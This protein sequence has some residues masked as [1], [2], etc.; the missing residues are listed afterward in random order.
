[1]SLSGRGIEDTVGIDGDPARLAG[2][3]RR[4]KPLTCEVGSWASDVTKGRGLAPRAVP[5]D[6]GGVLTL[7]TKEAP[8]TSARLPGA[9]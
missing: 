6:A 1:V 2:L 4:S 3:S 8:V 7:T 5:A 9:Q